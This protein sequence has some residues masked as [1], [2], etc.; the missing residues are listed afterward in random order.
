MTIADIHIPPTDKSPEVVLDSK[1]FIMIKGRGLVL[2]K[3]KTPEKISGWIENYVNNPS[4]TTEVFLAFE[5]L[6]SYS[7]TILV[8]TLRDLSQ[9]R[10]KNK[11]FII[12][13][14]YEDEDEDLFERGKNI[15]SILNIPIDFITTKDITGCLS[16][17]FDH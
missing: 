2:N 12:H 4:E 6:N 17:A 3:Y 14:Y 16:T 1:G 11:K 5:Y 13:W 8:S 9:V 7:T 10:L 15:S